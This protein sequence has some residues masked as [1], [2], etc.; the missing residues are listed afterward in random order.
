MDNEHILALVEAVH[1]AQLLSQEAN[2]IDLHPR[3]AWREARFHRQLTF[4]RIGLCGC[5]GI[6]R[7]WAPPSEIVALLSGRILT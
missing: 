7:K 5:G 2:E 3:L 6:V 1:G 4:L